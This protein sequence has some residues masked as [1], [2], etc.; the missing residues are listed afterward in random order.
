MHYLAEYGKDAAHWTYKEGGR[1][2]IS[3][4][5]AATD[6]GR[7]AS[8]AK[9]HASQQVSDLKCRPSGSP[10]QQAQW[11]SALV[12]RSGSPTD[13]AA[14]GLVALAAEGAAAAAGQAQEGASSTDQRSGSPKRDFAEYLKWS[15]QALVPHSADRDLVCLVAAG[16]MEVRAVPKGTSLAD[17]LA[18]CGPAAASAGAHVLVN[19]ELEGGESGTVLH[20]GDIVEV[21]ED[22]PGTT[23]LAPATAWGGVDTPSCLVAL[24]LTPRAVAQPAP[25]A[26]PP[27]AAAPKLAAFAP[28]GNVVPLAGLSAKLRKAAAMPNR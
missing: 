13:G 14:A 17:F 8:W 22:A 23:Q 10:A 25:V 21:Y 7:E 26:T 4:R 1:Q 24:P 15:G 19:R 28:T 27:V 5:G 2:S 3:H 11:M 6:D 20:T 12:A 9:Y 16:G 18:G